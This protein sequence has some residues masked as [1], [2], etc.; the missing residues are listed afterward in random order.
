MKKIIAVILVIAACGI[1]FASCGYTKSTT[2][3]KCIKNVE[4]AINKKD[5]KGLL[6]C[7]NPDRDWDFSEDDA[8]ELID[9]FYINEFKDAKKLSFKV[10]DVEYGDD[11]TECYVTVKVTAK[12]VDYEDKMVLSLSKVDGV[13]YLNDDF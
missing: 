1:I 12:G 13:W 7:F 2:P 10:S 4:T 9:D 8:K 11:K 3:E 6:K 5:A